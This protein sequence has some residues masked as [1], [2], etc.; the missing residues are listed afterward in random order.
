MWTIKYILIQEEGIKMKKITVYLF[1]VSAFITTYVIPV[2]ASG[3]G[4]N[5]CNWINILF[6]YCIIIIFG[7][8]NKMKKLAYQIFVLS[9]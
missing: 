2:M 4:G 5:W 9:I 3:G 6:V 8:I 7:R 1:L